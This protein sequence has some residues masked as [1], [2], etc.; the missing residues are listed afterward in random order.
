ML[1]LTKKNRRKSPGLLLLE[2]SPKLKLSVKLPD[3]EAAGESHQMNVED[4]DT[5]EPTLKEIEDEQA[6]D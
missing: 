4:S 6:N 2:K 3:K 5:D 1:S